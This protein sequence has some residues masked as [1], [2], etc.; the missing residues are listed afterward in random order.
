[1][2]FITN[3]EQIL[4]E[5]GIKLSPFLSSCGISTGVISQWRNGSLP[6]LEKLTR[7]S[8]M[9]DVSTDLLIFGFDK[10]PKLSEN[11]IKLLEH[12]RKLNLTKQG[13]VIGYT[14]RLGDETS[15]ERTLNTDTGGKAVV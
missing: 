15:Q 7:I 5:K 4:N 10:S 3:L 2:C 13:Q 12:F 11:E 6:S 9:L 1:M 14:E 8:A